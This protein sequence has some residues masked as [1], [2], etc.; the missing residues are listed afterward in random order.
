MKEYFAKFDPSEIVVDE[1]KGEGLGFNKGDSF[2]LQD[3]IPKG[4]CPLAYYNLVPYA[5]TLSH[6]GWFGWVRKQKNLNARFDPGNPDFSKSSINERFPNEVIVQCPNPNAGVVFGVGPAHKDGKK[7]VL[8]R[9]IGKAKDCCDGLKESDR[10]I[11]SEQQILN[12]FLVAKL[13][14]YWLANSISEKAPVLSKRE[15]HYYIFKHNEGLLKLYFLRQTEQPLLCSSVCS[16]SNRFFIQISNLKN[17]CRFHSDGI[18]NFDDKSIFVPSMCP[19]A[20][21][22]AYLL[23]I[24]EAYGAEVETN[25]SCPKWDGVDF[26]MLP[27]TRYP[28]LVTRFIKLLLFISQKINFPRDILTKKIFFKVSHVR[29]CPHKHQSGKCYELNLFDTSILCP[30]SSYSLFWFYFLKQNSLSIDWGKRKNEVA[31]PDCAGCEYE[32]KEKFFYEKTN[33]IL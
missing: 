25:F 32:V 2:H 30:A 20:F 9:V 3:Y 14:P 11:L 19:E 7:S 29:L 10:F 8:I 21:I 31:C 16:S 22:S 27:E 12:I 5:I 24:A 17:K 33:K 13:F 18:K 28:W 1:I 15:K 23:G 26:E 6:G 4:L